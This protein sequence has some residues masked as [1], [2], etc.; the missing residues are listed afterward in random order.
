MAASQ[1]RP[2]DPSKTLSNPTEKCQSGTFRKLF[3]MAWQGHP[4]QVLRGTLLP[5]QNLVVMSI[6]IWSEDSSVREGNIPYLP[7][8]FR[9]PEGLRLSAAK[10]IEVSYGTRS[11]WSLL[12]ELRLLSPRYLCGVC[13]RNIIQHQ[14]H[15]VEIYCVVNGWLLSNVKKCVGEFLK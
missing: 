7:L 12:W 15:T 14:S 3:Q 1:V 9:A 11:V 4:S 6:D 5:L 2:T 10:S 13:K 8:L